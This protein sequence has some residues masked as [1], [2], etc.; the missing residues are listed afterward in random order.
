MQNI[1]RYYLNQTTDNMSGHRLKVIVNKYIDYQLYSS[2][3]Y[4][5][6]LWA[7]ILLDLDTSIR[8]HQ[9]YKYNQSKQIDIGCNDTRNIC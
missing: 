9:M 2:H 4:C 7:L 3:I 5:L 8:G 1:C 6:L